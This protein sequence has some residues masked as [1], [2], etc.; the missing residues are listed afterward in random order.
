MCT[1]TFGKRNP[2]GFVASRMFPWKE[3]PKLQLSADGRVQ[4]GARYV[5]GFFLSY[6]KRN[7][8]SGL[9]MKKKKENI[10]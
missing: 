10:I 9:R 8:P 3:R 7:S 1:S 4:G 2:I 6:N 5:F